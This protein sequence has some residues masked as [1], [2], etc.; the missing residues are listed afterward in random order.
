M[1]N[2]FSNGSAWSMA[3][4]GVAALGGISMM[5]GLTAVKAPSKMDIRKAKDERARLKAEQERA[6]ERPGG[7]T[8]S[9]L[10]EHSPANEPGMS[11][12][13]SDVPAVEVDGH[14]PRP[15]WGSDGR[16]P[17]QA[18]FPDVRTKK[19][20]PGPPRGKPD[21]RS[22][23]P[24]GSASPFVP[25]Q[26][27]QGARTGGKPTKPGKGIG[28]PKPKPEAGTV[29]AKAKRTERSK[30]RRFSSKMPK[31]EDLALRKW[32]EGQWVDVAHQLILSKSAALC[33]DVP[34][35]VAETMAPKATGTLTSR[36]DSLRLYLQWATERKR[37]PFPVEPAKIND[38]L[39]YAAGKAPT[40]G[41]RFR[42]ALA[43]MRY[44]FDLPVL[45]V[46]IAR[47]RGLAI[48]GLKRKRPTKKRAGI[49]V[50]VIQKWERQVAEVEPADL[51][52]EQTA[53]VLIKGLL[54]FAV[55]ARL[56]FS[57]A[58]QITQEP[59]LQV[60][61]TTGQSY[62]TTDMKWGEHKT[63]NNPRKAGQTIPIMA[64]GEGLTETDWAAKW[65]ET[66]RRNNLDAA[67]DQTLM[68]EL[69]TD[70]SIGR[71]RMTSEAGRQFVRDYLAEESVE[72]VD[73]FGAHSGKV[74]VLNWVDIWGQL[75]D[76][77]RILGY[78]IDSN[79]KSQTEYTRA[80]MAAPMRG[81]RRMY[82]LIR[83]KLFFPDDTYAGVLLPEHE[84]STVWAT[85]SC[86]KRART[87]E[88][89]DPEV[90]STQESVVAATPE[91]Q[92]QYRIDQMIRR[93]AAEAQAFTEAGGVWSNLEATP[94]N[95]VAIRPRAIEPV[96]V[97]GT[98][99]E[100]LEEADG[101]PTGRLQEVQLMPLSYEDF[102]G[103]QQA[104]AKCPFG[105][106]A[107]HKQKKFHKVHADGGT[108]AGCGNV[109]GYQHYE[110]LH[111]WPPFMKGWAMCEKG[112][113][114]HALARKHIKD[115]SPVGAE[116]QGK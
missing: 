61:E 70:W 43:F 66:R 2:L 52:K 92:Q 101:E 80:M 18:R 40:R 8:V 38:Y 14:K 64:V 79:R 24:R 5:G 15:K 116:A 29:V 83:D 112:G 97:L 57:D 102:Q 73:L 37:P 93:A 31:E 10:E 3:T 68:R 105:I 104:L 96:Q 36:Y 95:Q 33:D 9:T 47:S 41:Q 34:Q 17:Y 78:H 98:M 30:L 32:A 27:N 67:T 69:L 62:L 71:G 87:A 19:P 4:T 11:S 46:Q 60:S 63:G 106:C 94:H 21:D 74:T 1:A 44:H 77:R 75:G 99:H 90:Q 107:N 13:N 42:E 22:A 26:V 6:K 89:K 54:L 113:C 20:L 108:K 100:Q 35:W 7:E 45:Q 109:I 25:L 88:T 23:C 103:A 111:G 59:Y 51:N 28:K 55:H 12:Y 76:H 39:R 53:E 85:T 110:R 50:W 56:R 16:A 86:P 65:L 48:M 84:G 49:P 72:D 81:I 91:E 58:A 82:G 114:F 115:I